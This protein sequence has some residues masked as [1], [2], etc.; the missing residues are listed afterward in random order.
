MGEVLPHVNAALNSV[1]SVLLVSGWLAI[2]S[3]RVARHRACMISALACSALF[4]ACYLVR[5]WLTGTHSYP[6][7][8]WERAFYLVLLL[9]H[10]TLAALVPALALRTL[11]L[12]LRG[13]IETH[14]RWA[15]VA[16]PI[17][18]YVSVSGVLVYWMLYH[19]A[20]LV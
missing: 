20:G 10:V 6:G 14:R 7:G 11:Y 5:H 8:G 16:L 9:S 13:R 4:L 19:R 17:W 18:L 12:A 3:G 15:R 1:S 2:R